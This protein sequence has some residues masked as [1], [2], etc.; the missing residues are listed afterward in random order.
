MK[1][2]EDRAGKWPQLLATVVG[3]VILAAG[4]WVLLDAVGFGP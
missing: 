1:R 2:P 3:Y 4:L